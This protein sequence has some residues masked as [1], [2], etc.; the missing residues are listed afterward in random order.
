MLNSDSSPTAPLMVTAPSEDVQITVFDGFDRIVGEI[1]RGEPQQ[2]TLDLPAGLYTI[3]SSWGGGFEEKVVRHSGPTQQKALLPSQFSAAPLAGAATSHEYYTRPTEQLSRKET[4]PPIGSGAALFLFIRASNKDVYKGQ[5]L[6][7]DLSVINETGGVV[8]DFSPGQIKR[9]T[10]DRTDDG[11]KTGWLAYSVQASSGFYFLQFGGNPPR[12]VPIQLYPNWQTQIFLTHHGRPLFEGMRIFMARVEQGF[13]LQGFRPKDEIADAVDKGLIGLQN[14]LDLLPRQQMRFLLD[15]KFENPMLGLIG[16]HLLLRRQEFDGAFLNFVFNNLDALLPNSPDVQ[17]LRVMAA[18]RSNIRA[19]IPPMQHPPMLRAGL[20]GVLAASANQP[21]LL[22]ENGLIES[23]STRL[24]ADSPWSSWALP[25]KSANN[26]NP[27]HP[28][29][30]WNDDKAFHFGIRE[31]R[32][33]GQAAGLDWVQRAVL[34]TLEH[35]LHAQKQEPVPDLATV[36]R[37]LQLSPRT[38]E[39]AWAGL[40]ELSPNEQIALAAQWRLSSSYILE[41][42]PVETVFASAKPDQK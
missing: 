34:D 21:E 15:G 41:G 14:N 12:Q 1:R 24:Y 23:V 36:A 40:L 17:A 37:Q 18:S 8:C 31:E 11:A 4:A 27:S 20:E 38:L 22:P 19:S 39:K 25:Q 10:D 16:A 33:T 6:A 2:L 13:H 28:V 29:F 26:G 5:N 3:R 7:E 32:A 30:P 9:I 42:S 35:A